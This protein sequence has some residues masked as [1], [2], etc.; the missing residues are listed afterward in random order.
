M[1]SFQCIMELLGLLRQY[2]VYCDWLSYCCKLLLFRL[3]VM[4]SSKDSNLVFSR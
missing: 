4:F 2:K 3:A 1:N